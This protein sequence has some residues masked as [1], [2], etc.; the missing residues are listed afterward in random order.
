MCDGTVLPHCAHLLSWGACQR[1][2]A[3]R[4]R[5]RIFEVLRFGTPIRADQESRK[6]RK[7]NLRCFLVLTLASGGFGYEHDHGLKIQFIQRAPIRW[8]GFEHGLAILFLDHL[9]HPTDP[10]TFP[11]AM[12]IGRQVEQNVFA[13]EWGEIDNFRTSELGVDGKILYFDIEWERFKTA[14]TMQLDRLGERP[15][16]PERSVRN[17]NLEGVTQR[18]RAAGFARIEL[19]KGA[20]LFPLEVESVRRNLA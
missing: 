11:I 8:T 14:D 6:I 18:T 15:V 10:S 17:S 9:G 19:R 1:C 20:V 3:L 7:G 12:R 2:D 16:R 13:N 4:V 5:N